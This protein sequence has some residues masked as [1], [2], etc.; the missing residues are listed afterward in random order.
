MEKYFNKYNESF[1]IKREFKDSKGNTCVEI[2]FDKTKNCYVCKKSRLKRPFDITDYNND[3]F[4]GTIWKQN[5]GDSVKVLK[6]TSIQGPDKS[7]LYEVEFLEVPYK[8]IISKS[9][10]KEG[11][12]F[13]PYYPDKFGYYLGEG[14]DTQNKFIF[15]NWRHLKERERGNYALVDKDFKCYYNFY[16]WCLN[17]IYEYEGELELDKD[18]LFNIKHL[19]QKIYSPETCIYLP[20]ELNGFLSG[21]SIIA[22]I[23]L[24]NHNNN[25]Y[26]AQYKYKKEKFVLYGNSFK[27]LKDNISRQKYLNWKNQIDKEKIPNDIKEILLQYDFSWSWIWENMTEEEILKKFY[28]GYFN[29]KI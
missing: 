11:K 28:N 9:H 25:I 3:T 19:N 8:R 2:E 4:I 20:R 1:N 17:N 24:Y 23:N 10:I 12:A 13:N 14:G 7:F 15:N 5:C 18:V 16:N 29:R 27:E 26:I 22:N 21:D 6:K